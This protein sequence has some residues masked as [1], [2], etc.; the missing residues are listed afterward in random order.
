MPPPTHSRLPFDEPTSALDPKLVGKV[1]RVMRDPTAEGRTMVVVTQEMGF[2]SDV[3]SQVVILYQG[4]IEE[5]GAPREVFANP[6]SER[7]RQFL[8]GVRAA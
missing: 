8:T 3:A 7:L 2:A 1:L 5:Q 6:K 4:L